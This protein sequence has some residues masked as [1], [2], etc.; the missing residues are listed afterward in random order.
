MAQ[1]DRPRLRLR[2]RIRPRS[3]KIRLRKTGRPR[4]RGKIYKIWQT[5]IWKHPLAKR[6][7]QISTLA[8]RQKTGFSEE[9]VCSLRKD[10][11]QYLRPEF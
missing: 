5:K 9:A 6:Q 3:L 11:G 7:R 10:Q 4:K 2:F 1:T 8:K